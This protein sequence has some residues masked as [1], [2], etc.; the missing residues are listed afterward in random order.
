L[1]AVGLYKYLPIDLPD[2][3]LN[4]VID[5]PSPKGRDLLVQIHAIAVNPL[6]IKMRSPQDKVE[7][8]P[9]ILGWDA[10][11]VVEAVGPEASLFKAG[12]EVFYAGSF[13][14]PGCN[15]E[16]HV[17]DERIVGSKPKSLDFAQA[18][19]MPL[20][21]ITAWEA[22]FVRLGIDVASSDAGKNLLVI[23]GAGGVGSIAIQFAK[24]LA[25]LNVTVTAS[26][27]GS[28]TWVKD[29]GVDHIINHYLDIPEQVNKLGIAG[30]EYILCLNDTDEHWQSMAAVV[31]PQGKICS[32]VETAADVDLGAL[33]SKSASFVWEFMFTRSM[34]ET[35]DMIEQHHLLNRVAELVD[36]GTIKTT[37]NKVLKP[38]NAK[39]LKS[40]HAEIE[41]RHAI[42]KIVLEG[43]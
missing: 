33:K 16:F 21:S 4:V 27:P 6:D 5:K 18:A 38:I 19:A 17:V 28:K 40:A 13:V 31:A 3:L 8:K 15:S 36:A 41:G 20:T 10:A 1:K 14:R 24:Q 39:N 37:S 34:Y 11:G 30:Y 22:M 42:G 7:E 32:I 29:L 2:S 25:K 23:G 26:R 9:R 12:D 43:W 35:D